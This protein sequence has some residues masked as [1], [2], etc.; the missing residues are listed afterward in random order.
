[1][2]RPI[3]AQMA[4]AYAD[5][6]IVTDDNPRTENAEKIIADIMA[7]FKNPENIIIENDRAKAI[8]LAIQQANVD[9]FV[10]IAGKGHETY[11][12]IGTEKKHFSDFEVAQA[13]M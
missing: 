13:A 7:G 2:K 6:V 11:Q 9:D 12:I 5:N 3:M 10:L 1:M 8:T 4:E